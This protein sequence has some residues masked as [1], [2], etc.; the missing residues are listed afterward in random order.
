MD[1]QSNYKVNK[2]AMKKICFLIFCFI[3]GLILWAEDKPSFPGGE[4]AL[5]KYIAEKTVYPEIAKENGIEG[6]VVVGF[7]VMADGSLNEFK[8]IKFVDPDLENEALLVVK[9]MPAWMPAEKD[10]APIEAPSKVEVPF[11]LE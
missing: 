5:K 1:G 7:M 9:G 3:S 2:E 4:E 6:I 10:G 11:L 8:I